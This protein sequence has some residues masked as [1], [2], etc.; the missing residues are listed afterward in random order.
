[1]QTA[2]VVAFAEALN[3]IEDIGI[4][5]K[6]GLSNI[7]VHGGGPRIKRELDKSG[8]KSKFIRGLR[9]TDKKIINVVEKEIMKGSNFMFLIYQYSNVKENYYLYLVLK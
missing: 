2:E 8:I 4:V 5:H 9:V 1:M 7:V 3:F 6:L